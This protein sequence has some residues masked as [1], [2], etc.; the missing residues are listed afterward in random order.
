[1]FYDTPASQSLVTASNDG[2]IA[3]ENITKEIYKRLYHNAPYLLNNKGT[4][5]GIRALM[6]CYGLPSTILNIKEYGGPVKDKTGYKT[7]SSEKH[8]YAYTGD[9]G[10]SGYFIKT[11]WSSSLTP[12]N[13]PEKTVTFRIKPYRTDNNYHLF[14]LSGSSTTTTPNH[15]DGKF[16]THLV[17]VPYTGTADI[18]SSGDASQYGKLELYMGTGSI[19]STENFPIYD[20]NYWNIHVGAKRNSSD[21]NGVVHIGAYKSNFLKNVHKHTTS[22]AINTSPAYYDMVWGHGTQGAKKASYG[23][24]IDNGQAFYDVVGPLTYSGSFQEINVHSGELLSDDTLTKHALDPFMYS[25]NTVSSSFHNL[26][27]RLP[28]GSNNILN[29]QIS[30]SYHPNQHI[31]Y[32]T[33]QSIISNMSAQTWEEVVETHHLPTPDTVGAAMTSEKVRTDVGTIDDNILSPYIKSETST[34]DRQAQDFE[35]LGVFFS[36]QTEIN[37]DIIYTLGSFRLDDYIGDPRHQT[38][39]NY[40]DLKELREKYFQ[41]YTNKQKYNIWDYTKLIQYIDH[42]LFKIIEQH[43]PA[44]ANLKTGLLIEPH[45]LERNKFARSLPTTDEYR[46]MLHDSH[47]HF[48]V[49]LDLKQIKTISSSLHQVTSSICVSCEVG[50]EPQFGAQA[51]INP[52][53]TTG[54][55]SHYKP[56]QSSVLLGNATDSRLSNIYFRSLQLGKE[57]DY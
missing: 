28:L 7:F 47:Q 43:T 37:E 29:Y 36:P 50:N 4:E 55:P 25:G 3:K 54:T 20:G 11:D 26:I 30:G 52:V 35:D 48:R 42:T 16:D 22:S 13:R 21:A 2:S 32:F 51:P 33:S 57:T 18:S 5:R 45:Y 53:V 8:S 23:G 34:L 1:M 44:K 14:S 56:Y 27:L 19:V 39:S 17:L 31:E 9:T 15:S 38:S 10:A 6:N 46:T 41:K 12:T 24:V 49:S 40:P